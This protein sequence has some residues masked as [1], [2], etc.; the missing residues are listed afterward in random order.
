MT[1]RAGRAAPTLMF[2][3]QNNNKN[4]QRT[5]DIDSFYPVVVAIALQNIHY[6]VF[7][8]TKEEDEHTERNEE[9]EEEEE[10]SECV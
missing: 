9:E 4:H 1:L 2:R 6:S 10:G 8:F 3:A 7:F 5:N